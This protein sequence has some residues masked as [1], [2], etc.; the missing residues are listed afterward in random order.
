MDGRGAQ[1]SERVITGPFAL[2]VAST[3][4]MF[5]AVGVIVVSLPRFVENELGGGG[6]EVGLVVG[7]FSV[8]AVLARPLAGRLGDQRGRKL[9]LV[10]G[11]GVTAVAFALLPL[12]HN[13]PTL[14]LLRC[15][16]GA[17]EAAFYI[18]A[19]AR[20]ADLAPR[21]RTGEAMSYFSVALYLGLAVG[22]TIGETVVGDGHYDRAWLTAGLLALVCM[23][24]ASFVKEGARPARRPE[25]GPLIHPAG[26]G[27]GAALGLGIFGFAAF[28]AFLPLH[29]QALGAGK[30]G[31]VFAIFAGVTLIGRVAGARLPDRLGAAPVARAGIGGVA[32]GML[33]MGLWPSMTGVYVGTFVFAAGNAFVFPSLFLL[34]VNNAPDDER[35]AVVGTVSAFFDLAQG[36]GALALGPLAAVAG[37]GATFVAGGLAAAAGV[38]VITALERGA[39]RP[40]YAGV[41]SNRS[42]VTGESLPPPP[43]EVR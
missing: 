27:P 3:L 35:A 11:P 32:L 40:A 14:F 26:L 34:A 43:P 39:L 38:V 24:L 20:I 2:M 8:A 4:A 17:G 19:A 9:L 5:L 15:L 36:A 10:A 29:T 6:V 42:V 28:A 22:P 13:I 16:Q 12:A 31:P 25:R 7:A 18:G 37:Y 23:A 30:A 41:R 33:I 21:E 1:A